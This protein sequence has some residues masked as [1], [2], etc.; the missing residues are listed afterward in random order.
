MIAYQQNEMISSSEAAKRFG[1]ILSQVSSHAVEKIA[2][3]KNNQIEAVLVAPDEYERMKEALELLEHMEIYRTLQ[4]RKATPPAQG[5]SLDE[6]L[7][8]EGI[9]A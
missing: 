5:I 1:A 6:L 8:G 7:S 9:S 4:T 3:L 2:V